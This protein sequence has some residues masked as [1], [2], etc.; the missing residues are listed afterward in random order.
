MD[1]DAAIAFVGEAVARRAT[2]LT[3]L[4]SPERT[5]APRSR[6]GE[7]NRPWRRRGSARSEGSCPCRCRCQCGYPEESW[8]RGPRCRVR[9]EQKPASPEPAR[10][11]VPRVRETR[12]ELPSRPDARFLECCAGSRV[13]ARSDAALVLLTAQRP[14]ES[15]TT[16]RS[17]RPRR[18]RASP[19]SAAAAR[20]C[21]SSARWRSCRGRGGAG[22]FRLAIASARRIYRCSDSDLADRRLRRNASYQ[23]S[24][25][26]SSAPSRQPPARMCM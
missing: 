9:R 7:C 17:W 8:A 15:A 10:P 25:R 1:G 22:T 14:A 26:Q 20:V 13:L 11:R 24:R 6:E 21:G 12:S 18:A 3:T 5:T 19:Q 23:V 16:L 2:A 4:S